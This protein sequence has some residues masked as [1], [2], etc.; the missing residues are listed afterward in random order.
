M[1]KSFLHNCIKQ[2]EMLI[3]WVFVVAAIHLEF[4]ISSLLMIAFVFNRANQNVADSLKLILSRYEMASGQ[5]INM[6]KSTIT[7][8][9]NTKND[10][11]VAIMNCMGLSS[12]SLHDKYLELPCYWA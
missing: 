12:T 1:L 9:P 6:E 8:S 2:K 5:K 4:P 11:R 3:Y 10:I 7:F